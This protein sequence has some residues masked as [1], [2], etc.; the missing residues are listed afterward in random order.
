M[1]VSKP[2]ARRHILGGKLKV[3]TRQIRFLLVAGILMLA[4]VFAL[5]QTMKRVHMHRGGMFGEHQLQFFTDYLDLTDAQQAQAKE[6]LA[7]G[8]PTIQPLVQ[9]MKDSRRQLHQL[10]MSGAFD[11]GKV[12][13]L[14]AQQSQTMTELIVQKARIHSEL[15]Q[16]LT[17]DQKAKLSK[18]MG[19]HEQRF[20]KHA[21]P[22]A[23]PPSE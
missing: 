9:Q 17:P 14:A 21:A 1:Y 2:A 11:E 3:K 23:A 4:A 6:I 20:L 19:R 7:K 10:E 16:I 12:R 5:S 13:N 8:K 18:F 22:E 15:V